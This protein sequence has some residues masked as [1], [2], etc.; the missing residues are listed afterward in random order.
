ADTDLITTSFYLAYHGLNDVDLQRS[1]AR[2][3]APRPQQPNAHFRTQ[4]LK[5][6]PIRVGF[7]SRY[8][9][10]HTIGKLNAGLIGNLSRKLFEVSVVALEP[11][12]DFRA[13]L[14]RSLAD[15]YIPCPLRLSEAVNT[16]AQTEF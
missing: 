5:D 7:I 6:R 9:W 16:L 2:L 13:N 10:D 1:V 11:R 14:I 15:H 8:F 12:T 3:Y 4:P